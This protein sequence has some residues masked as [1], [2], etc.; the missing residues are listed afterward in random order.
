MISALA[1]ETIVHVATTPEKYDRHHTLAV[2][3]SGSCVCACVSATS[4]AQF[5]CCNFVDM[6][7]HACVSC[8]WSCACVHAGAVY[9]FGDATDGK[10]GLGEAHAAGIIHTP[11]IVSALL[12]E[13]IIKVHAAS[14]S[15]TT[16]FRLNAQAASPKYLGINHQRRSLA[17]CQVGAAGAHSVA[18][19]DRGTVFSWGTHDHNALVYVKH[20]TRTHARTHAR[21]LYSDNYPTECQATGAMAAWALRTQ[22]VVWSNPRRCRSLVPT[23]A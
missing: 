16:C 8:G 14:R 5:Q 3:A 11:Q 12:S 1:S 23:T 10:L 19:S 15:P 18:L 13:N 2:T 21:Q 20:N 22:V 7:H 17:L 9:A 4:C 6:C